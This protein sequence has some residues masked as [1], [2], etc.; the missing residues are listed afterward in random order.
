MFSCTQYTQSNPIHHLTA[1]SQH[2]GNSLA[3]SF[4]D[5]GTINP[6]IPSN[7]ANH[8]SQQTRICGSHPETWV[9]E[10]ELTEIAVERLGDGLQYRKED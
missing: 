3:Q 5:I 2:Y 4:W 7:P 6:P 10:T 1:S 9:P 8:A